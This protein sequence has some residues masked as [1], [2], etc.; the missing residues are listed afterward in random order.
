MK[1]QIYLLPLALF[2]SLSGAARAAADPIEALLVSQEQNAAQPAAKP[3]ANPV[4]LPPRRPK[5]LGAGPSKKAPLVNLN[6]PSPLWGA[7]AARRTWTETT[8]EVVSRRLRDL[9]RAKDKEAFCPSYS[10]ASVSQKVN[11]WVMLVSAVSKLES[12][13]KTG[14]AFKESNGIDS[15]GLLALSPGECPNAHTARALSTAA[16]NL[17]C[18]VNMMARLV[19][20][21]HYISGPAD[22]RGAA[23]YWSTLRPPY[24]SYDARFHRNLNLGYKNQIVAMTRVYRGHAAAPEMAAS[25]EVDAI[26]EVELGDGEVFEAVDHDVNDKEYVPLNDDRD[27]FEPRF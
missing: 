6:L 9:E 1:K 18:G 21:D 23:R 22:H 19:A 11:C 27:F 8:R 24:K 2:L 14:D 7:T 26:Y 16:A 10:K 20:Q 17:V 5:D 25:Y 4:P 3:L 12:G 13:F 15:I